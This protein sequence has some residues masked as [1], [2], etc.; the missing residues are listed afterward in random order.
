MLIW[1]SQRLVW[2]SQ[3]QPLRN[4]GWLCQ[5]LSVRGDKQCSRGD[6]AWR[7]SWETKAEIWVHFNYPI[8]LSTFRPIST[9]SRAILWSFERCMYILHLSILFNL[10]FK[11][12]GRSFV[13]AIN[14]GNFVGKNFST[15]KGE[16]LKSDAEGEFKALR[17]NFLWYL[18]NPLP[19]KKHA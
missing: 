3:S 10:F 14:A 13:K 18:L 12:S 19:S 5:A 15:W 11:V 6:N 9:R 4:N 7:L 1:I 17:G 8:F 2:P 16:I